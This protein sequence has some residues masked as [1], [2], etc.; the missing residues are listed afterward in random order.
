MNKL[1]S[2]LINKKSFLIAAITIITLIA[3]VIC[4]FRN[5]DEKFEAT[6]AAMGTYVT[7]ILCGPQAKSICLDV[8]NKIKALE[9]QISWRIEGSDIHKINSTDGPVSIS[10]STA[11]ILLSSIDVAKK[12]DGA[13][14]PAILPLTS[15]WDFGGANNVPCKNEISRI[16]PMLDYSSLNVDYKNLTAALNR[17]SGIDLGAVGKGAACDLA[18]DEYKKSGVSFGIVSVGGSIGVFGHKPDNSPF[19][20]AIRNPFDKND[21]NNGFAVLEIFDGC[22]STSGSYERSFCSDGNFYHHI[23]NSSTGYPVEN[24][25]VCVT[26]VHKNGVL[27]D[28]LSTACFVLGFEKSLTLLKQYDAS[29]VFVCKDKNIFASE[30]LRDNL[31]ITDDSFHIHTWY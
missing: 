5:K 29:A 17:K 12:S 22:V 3:A 28:L 8:N 16:L 18:I 20:I 13:F 11:D 21:C 19:K 14:N 4:G 25:L 23:L 1:N 27:T 7:Q 9:N 15:L 31:K 6:S 26:V 30:T 24:N 10:K 2:K